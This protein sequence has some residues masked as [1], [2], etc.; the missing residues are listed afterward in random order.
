MIEILRKVLKI[1]I[2]ILLKDGFSKN[3]QNNNKFLHLCFT[4]N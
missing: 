4:F 2:L 1:K 3:L